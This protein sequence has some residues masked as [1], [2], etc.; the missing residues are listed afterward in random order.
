M[1]KKVFIGCGDY[2]TFPIFAESEETCIYEEG[3]LVSEVGQ[4]EAK[5]P[6]QWE[7]PAVYDWQGYDYYGC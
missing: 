7:T 4:R 3:V 1:A 5:D 2:G 6:P